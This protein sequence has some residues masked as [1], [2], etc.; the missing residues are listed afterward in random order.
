MK[1]Q[2][3]FAIGVIVLLSVIV[4]TFFGTQVSIDQFQIYMT[5]VE[6]TNYDFIAANGQKMIEI[7]YDPITESASVHLEYEYAPD[8]ATHPEHVTFTLANATYTNP[9]TGVT[10]TYATI[11]RWGIVTFNN[12]TS[13]RLIR[14]TIRTTDGSNLTDTVAIFCKVN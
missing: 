10:T 12:L 3:I 6:I 11:D 2:V 14:V 13:S 4:V 9:T 7:N 8:D 5:Q 1:K